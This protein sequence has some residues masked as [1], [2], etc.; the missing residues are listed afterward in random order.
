MKNPML[1]D[2][3]KF[4][5]SSINEEHMTVG[6]TVAKTFIYLILLLGA[7]L[8]SFMQIQ[9]GTMGAKTSVGLFIG[10][11]ISSFI[12]SLIT[13][14]IPKIAWLTAPIY[15]TLE[16]V[17]IGFI[18]TLIEHK[19]PGIV[20]Q[21][22]LATIGVVMAMLFLYAT[23]IIKVNE[24]FLNVVKIATLSVLIIYLVDI[25]LMLCG[26]PVPFLHDSSPLS[27]GISL[28]IIGIA[29]LNLLADFFFI[30]E[31]VNAKA[32]KYMEAYFGFALL[33]SI[34]WLYLEILKWL[35]KIRK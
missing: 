22:V 23:R 10:I 9:N 11:L 24:K 26:V 18:S 30:E 27:I 17:L 12:I 4:Q 25:A 32:P 29:S 1:K 16:G 19:Y 6:G 5:Q 21:A 28:I 7:S 15:A 34:V 3:E 33:V 8:Y 31:G 20:V 35:E 14:T 2:K 13:A